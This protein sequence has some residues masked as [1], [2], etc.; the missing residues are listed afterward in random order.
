[1]DR[2]LRLVVLMELP[3]CGISL[4]AND[5][6]LLRVVVLSIPCA[7][8]PIDIGFALPSEEALTLSRSGIS[9]PRLS[10]M[11]L[12]L[13]PKQFPSEREQLPPIAAPSV[14]LLMAPLCLLDTPITKFA[15][16]L[17]LATLKSI[18]LKF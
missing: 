10:S 4:K 6:I 12:K 11:S 7:S 15:F 8:P 17:L 13:K 14:G 5:F 16:T 9:N 18:L 1:M 2:S 3:S